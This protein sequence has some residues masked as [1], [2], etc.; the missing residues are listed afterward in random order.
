MPPLKAVPHFA[1]EPGVATAVGHAIPATSTSTEGKGAR[2]MTAIRITPIPT[3]TAMAL[4]ASGPDANGMP[5]ERHISDG[6]G[7]PCRHCLKNVDAGDA[8]LI[9]AHRPF[10]AAQPYAEVGPIFLHADPCDAYA[11]HGQV[12]ELHRGGEPRIVRGYGSDSRIVYG[13]GRVVT[14]DEI[15]D[16]AAELLS[17]DDIAFV[18]VRSSTNNCYAFRIDRA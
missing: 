8:Y 17:R 10:D 3:E 18:H 16:Y 4:W 6:D 12:P 9:L 5:P 14:G 13:T 1:Q 15:A 2:T 7:V 11:D